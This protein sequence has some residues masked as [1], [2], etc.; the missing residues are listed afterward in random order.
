M[1]DYR[2]NRE[3]PLDSFTNRGQ[4]EP[5][6]A[7]VSVAVVCTAFSVYAGV[8]TEIIPEIG[9]DRT[10]GDPAADSIWQEISDQDIYDERTTI[11][12]SLSE[13]ALPEGYH[14]AVEVTVV[15]ETG[16]RRTVGS[17]RFDDS[18]EVA[19][20]DPPQEGTERVERPV[21]VRLQSGEIRPGRLTV[22]VWE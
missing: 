3:C 2:L 18:G 20:I 19:A 21:S 14:S 17:A 16:S 10:V 11:P 9:S 12:T 8:A 4:S 22:V 1:T 5:L 13:S 15:T 7:L 6:A